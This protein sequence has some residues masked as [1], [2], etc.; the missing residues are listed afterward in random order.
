MKNYYLLILSIFSSFGFSQIF[1]NEIDTDTPSS[2]TKEFIELKSVTPNFLLTGYVLVFFNANTAGTGSISY[3][4]IDLDGYTTDGNGNIL[5]GNQFVSPTPAIIFPNSTLQNGP[6]AVAIFQANATDY[7]LN[8]IATNDNLIDAL[9]YSSSSGIQ[10]TSLISIFGLT[11]S[12]N[13]NLNAASDL[14][15]IQRKNDGT[16]EVKAPTPGINNDGTGIVFNYLSFS[17][18]NLTLYEGQ[19][20][21]INFSTTSPVL[22]V[23]LVI[24]FTLNNYSFNAADFS[25][26]LTAIIPVGSSATSANISIIND[27][28]NEGDEELKIVVAAIPIQYT[29]NNN[30]NIV[31]IND[32]NFASLPFGAPAN[33]TYGNVINAQPSGYYD[34]LNGLSGAGLKQEIQNIIANPNIVRAQSYGDVYDILKDADQNPE[35]NNQVWL[36]YSE[37]PRSKID[38]QTSNSIIGKWNRE[39]IYAQSRGGFIDGTSS[40]SDGINTWLPTS[41]NDILAGH[42]D[43]HHI[44]AVDGQENSSRGNKNYGIDY[45]GP[46][47]STSNSWKGDVARALFYMAVRYNGL[48]VVN[49]NPPET[50][51]GYIGDLATL[52]TWNNI[53]LADDFEMNRNNI[54]YNWQKNRNPFIDLPNLASYVFGNNIGQPFSNNLSESNNSEILSVKMF[55]NPAIDFIKIDGLNTEANIQIINSLGEIVYSAVYA[56]N[57]KLILN[58]PTGI[59]LVKITS[60]YKYVI[61]KLIIN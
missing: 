38:L 8:T 58:L 56:N 7:T 30:N 31:R 13:E 14:Q 27:G 24:N 52:L 25:G 17:T 4:A 37:E 28:N 15:S 49:G 46:A 47:G 26:S 2:D 48:N 43:V 6:D 32:V 18:N 34:S 10:P 5:L 61:K 54:I 1:I 42:A 35:N 23:P 16:Y 21:T 50:P 57:N 33:P 29:L 12:I 20:L 3:Y 51:D 11:S 60:D 19:N 59:Y 39:H 44:R 36:I 53:D 55:P 22:G 9:A 45:N 41:A 40:F